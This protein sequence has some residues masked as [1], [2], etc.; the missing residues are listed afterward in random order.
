VSDEVAAGSRPS[1]QRSRPMTARGL[2]REKEILDAAAEVFAHKGYSAANVEDVASIV[3]MLK[4]SLYYYVDSKEDLLYRLTKTIHQD[5]LDTLEETKS[6]DGTPEERLV[7]LVRLH[8]R[9]L[10]ANIAYTRVFYHEF[11]HLTGDRYLEIV[12]LRETYEHYVQDLVEEGQAAASFCRRRDAHVM[13]I[14]I[15]TLLNSVQQW[16]RPSG[17]ISVERLSNEYVEFVV[18]GLRCRDGATCSCE[19]DTNPKEDAK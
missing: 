4:G 11:R 9:K 1:V 14:A 8:F 12:R 18:S 13:M 10:T 15:L 5:A 6:L 19:T 2:Q 17:G 3:G 7:A 16:Y